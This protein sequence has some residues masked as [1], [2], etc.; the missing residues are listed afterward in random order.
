[1]QTVTPQGRL[2]YPGIDLAHEQTTIGP[3]YAVL[4]V[5]TSTPFSASRMSQAQKFLIEM[6][7]MRFADPKRLLVT[8]M[9]KS[10]IAAGVKR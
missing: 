2:A 10:Q 1:M 4:R 3:R 6:A 7:Y 5:L 8:S 9:P